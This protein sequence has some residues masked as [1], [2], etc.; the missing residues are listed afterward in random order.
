M[1]L[2]G[3]EADRLTPVGYGADHPIGD[4]ETTAGRASNRRIEFVKK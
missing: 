1:I 2:K 4:N 3:V